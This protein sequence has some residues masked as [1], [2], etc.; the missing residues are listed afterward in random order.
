M[1]SLHIVYRHVHGMH[2]H[3]SRDPHKVRPPWFSHESCFANLLDTIAKSSHRT[4][5][6]LSIVYDGTPDEFESDFIKT[7]LH[8]YPVSPATAIIVDAG[9]NLASWHTAIDYAL[10][11]NIQD[12]DFIYFLENDYLHQYGWLEKFFELCESGIMF[13]YASLYDH[14]DKYFYSMYSDLVSK[15]FSAPSHHWRTTPSTCGSFLVRRNTFAEDAA[16]WARAVQDHFQFQDLFEHKRRLLVSPIPGL[17]THCMQGYLSP[18]IEWEK[19]AT[20]L[21]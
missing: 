19:L 2:N 20:G 14:R 21:S 5:V 17:S 13:D 9:S 11:A 7:V 4:Q 15:I 6:S 3:R 18:S 8:N 12:T 1:S 10:K 16:Y